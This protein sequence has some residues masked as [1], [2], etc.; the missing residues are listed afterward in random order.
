MMMALRASSIGALVAGALMFGAPAVAAAEFCPEWVPPQQVQQQAPAEPPARPTQFYPVSGGAKS[1]A[2]DFI[3]DSLSAQNGAR[4]PRTTAQLGHDRQFNVYAIG[5]QTS[6]TIADLFAGVPVG[7]DAVGVIWVGRNNVPIGDK[8]LDDASRIAGR[9]ESGRYVVV[10][11]LPGRYKADQ[12]GQLN[13]A[14]LD[15][16][17]TALRDHFGDR[18][19]DV[20]GLLS[21]DDYQDN[22][23]LTD[24][25]YDKV[26]RAVSARIAELGY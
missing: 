3:G 24:A 8:A 4:F 19:V 20:V 1:P 14:K 6:A 12:P 2:L 17:N 9:F 25:G 16:A 18:F 22:I 23:H 10:G 21:C 26:A 15:K 13:R 5:G 11:I 7:N